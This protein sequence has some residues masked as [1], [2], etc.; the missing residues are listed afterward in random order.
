LIASGVGAAGLAGLPGCGADENGTTSG[1][2]PLAI[3]GWGGDSSAAVK[4]ELLV[5]FTKATGVETRLIEA[6]GEFVPRLDAMKKAGKITWDAL[7]TI[8]AYQVPE[9]QEKGY[10]APLPARLKQKFDDLGV[11]ATDFGFTWASTGH[12]VACN[13]DVVEKCPTTIEEF[14][15]VE[16]FPGSR[17]IYPDAPEVPVTMAAIAAGVPEEELFP[18]DLD[19]AFAQ[20]E[21]IKPHVKVW[22][23]SGDQGQQILRDGEVGIELAWS[24]RAFALKNEKSTNLQIEW[25]GVYE[26]GYWGVVSESP[27]TKEAF[28]LLE[29]IATQPKAQARY[30]ERIQYG[31]SNPKAFDYMDPDTAASLADNPANFDKLVQVDWQWF[32]D[33]SEEVRSRWQ[34]VVRT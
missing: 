11:N 12:I 27:N 4:E 29:W 1:A 25:A 19:K 26:P 31:V 16:N 8:A 30:A 21:K 15:D 17:A 33:N 23:T 32:A 18:L 6:N 34:D 5:P 2:G 20:I 10:L 22:Y 3:A 9:L 24:G 13:M 7:D 14:F 28:R